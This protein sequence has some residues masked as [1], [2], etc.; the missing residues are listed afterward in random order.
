MKK[1]TILVAGDDMDDRFLLETAFRETS[2]G[3]EE[4]HFVENGIE[5]MEYLQQVARQKDDKAFP[6]IIILDL[7]MPKKNG[8]E[9]L[10]EIKN[11][12][13]YKRIPVIVYTTTR[14][15]MEVKTCYEMGANTYIVKPTR[16]DVLC[17]VAQSI[18]TY[19][20]STASIP[21][22]VVEL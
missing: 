10:L 17:Q 22:V 16:F 12:P 14:N 5:L 3:E 4:L 15:E 8:K 2:N 13:L 19:W 21:A 11:H 7:N 9:A 18:R 1:A 6:E 20:L